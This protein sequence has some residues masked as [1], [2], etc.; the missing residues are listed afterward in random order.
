[1]GIDPV[2]AVVSKGKVH[3][4]SVYLGGT[5]VKSLDDKLT[6]YLVQDCRRNS[7]HTDRS[8]YTCRAQPSVH[9]RHVHPS[10]CFPYLSQTL[11]NQVCPGDA[12]FWLLF[13]IGRDHVWKKL[14]PLGTHVS[15][16]IPFF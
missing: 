12:S 6:L 14:K 1:M 5:F 7:T 8:T 2:E 13:T 10:S 15:V 4:E 11:V 9:K 16:G 3:Y